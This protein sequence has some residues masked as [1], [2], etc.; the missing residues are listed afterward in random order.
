MTASGVPEEVF[1]IEVPKIAFSDPNLYAIKVMGDGSCFFHSVLRA[2]NLSY[3]NATASSE[4]KRLAILVRHATADSL[5]EKNHTTGKTEYESMG[6]GFYKNYNDAVKDVEG[7]RYSLDAMKR[8]LMSSTPVDHAYTEIL[9]NHLNLDIYLISSQT[10]D[11]YATGTD[12]KLYFKDRRSIV[13][14]YSP[15]HY[16][17]I[18]IKRK[19]TEQEDVIFDTLF[20]PTHEFIAALRKRYKDITNR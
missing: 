12:I 4:R 11:I 10:G 15:G 14:L 20:A 17:V 18:G 7:D 6:G 5:E 13:I 2:F 1:R 16:D 19:S 9:S 8:E 3:I